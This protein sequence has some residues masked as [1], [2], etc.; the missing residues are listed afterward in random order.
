MAP[1]DSKVIMNWCLLYIKNYNSIAIRLKIKAPKCIDRYFR[2][3]K[4]QVRSLLKKPTKN[5]FNLINDE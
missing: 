2:E 5:C 1:Y 4:I 3:Y